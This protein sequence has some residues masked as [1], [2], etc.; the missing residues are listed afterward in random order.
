MDYLLL[1]TND[2]LLLTD[3]SKLILSAFSY[4]NYGWTSSILEVDATQVAGTTDLTNFPVLVSDVSLGSTG[5]GTSI[6]SLTQSDGADIRFSSDSL[7]T[8]PLDYELVNWDTTAEEGEVWVK[9]GTL[10][11]TANT[12]FYIWYD[13]GTATSASNGTA[14]WSNNY[15]AVYHLGNGGTSAPDSSYNNYTLN[16][17]TSVPTQVDGQVGSAVDFNGSTQY[18][19]I[20]DGSAPNLEISSDQAWSAWVYLDTLPSTYG[21]R[22]M[23]KAKLSNAANR[24]EMYI[25]HTNPGKVIYWLGG[26]STN[27]NVI[28]TGSVSAS[29]WTHIAGV[30]DSTNSKLKVFINGVKT[31]VTASGTVGDSNADLI[32]AAS[33]FGSGDS[34]AQWFNG[35]IDEVFISN[36]AKTD[37]WIQTYY[38]NTND[39][40]AFY[41][42]GVEYTA[43]LSD[44]LSMTD[45]IYRESNF[46]RQETNVINLTDDV[47]RT[48]DVIATVAQD[49]IGITDFIDLISLLVIKVA[50]DTVGIT[51]DVIRR[52]EFS[53]QNINTVTAT[54]IIDRVATFDRNLTN[55]VSLTDSILGSIQ[56]GRSIIDTINVT[57]TTTY[58]KITS[59]V[60]NPIIKF[61]QID[62]IKPTIYN[63]TNG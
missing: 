50:Q 7:G 19:S 14:V 24:H 35:A 2:Y 3:D 45:I 34:I 11:A 44:N 59:D 5:L 13:N 18:M 32:M 23:H 26:L 12:Q 37:E 36:D 22:V 4:S 55:N 17:G 20:A 41:V 63:I 30:Y 16:P 25:D 58:R 1:T 53:R 38:N 61:M 33:R 9:L 8:N 27:V 54:D 21:Y 57:D 28:S 49:T 42:G 6:W 10:Q 31:E 29:T 51:D 62:E 39:P 15:Q 52:A 47:V 48:H 46:F 60:E 43:N 56:I 40:F